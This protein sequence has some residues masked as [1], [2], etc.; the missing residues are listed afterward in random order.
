MSWP[1]WQRHKPGCSQSPFQ[2]LPYRQMCVCMLVVPLWC[3]LGRC[4][5]TVMVIKAAANPLP[6]CMLYN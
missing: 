4:S 2:P 6:L 5:Q 3:D 1:S